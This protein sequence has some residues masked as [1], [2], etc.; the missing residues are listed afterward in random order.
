[1]SVW[2][3]LGAAEVAERETGPVRLFPGPLRI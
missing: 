3:V 2:E 1:V